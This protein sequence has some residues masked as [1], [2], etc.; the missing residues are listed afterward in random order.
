MKNEV[1][2]ESSTVPVR[3]SFHDNAAVA[4]CCFDVVHRLQTPPD[5]FT[6]QE[7]LTFLREKKL[8][9]VLLRVCLCVR[10]CQFLDR[11]IVFYRKLQHP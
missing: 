5:S 9:M 11:V 3:S 2:K 6:L 4:S 7:L 1:E 8:F 10:M